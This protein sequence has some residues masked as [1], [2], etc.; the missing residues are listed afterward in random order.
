MARSSIACARCRRSKVKCVNSGV[1]SICKACEMSGRECTYP[2][3]GATITPKRSE[4][5]PGVKVEDGEN[6]RKIRKTDDFAR[7]NAPRTGEDVLDAPILSKAVYRS[8]LDIFKRHFSTEMSFLHPSFRHRLDQAANPRDPSLPPLVDPEGT[9]LLVLAML[10]LTARFHPELV[11]YHSPGQPIGASEYYATAL[12][13]SNGLS[14][15]S[16]ST[17][18]LERIQALLMLGLYEWDQSKGG[19]AWFHVGAAIRLAQMMELSYEDDMD[20]AKQTAKRAGVDNTY[21]KEVRRR[22]MWSCFVMDRMLSCGKYRDRMVNIDSLKLRLPCADSLFL[23]GKGAPV[24]FLTDPISQHD[25]GILNRYIRL[26][27][28]W[29]E[30]SIWSH[31]GGRRT[32]TYPP[33][34]EKSRFFQLRQMLLQFR[35]ELPDDLAMNQD[36]LRNHI[37]GG[38]GNAYTSLHT[39]NLISLVM[40]HREYIPHIALRCEKPDGPIDPPLF[41]KDQYKIPDGFWED[42][43][44]VLFRSARD[45]VD[46]VQSCREDDNALPESAQIVFALFTAAYTGIYAALF[47]QM[48]TVGHM[49]RSSQEIGNN[50]VGYSGLVIK[51]LKQMTPRIPMAGVYV[52]KLIFAKSSLQAHREHFLTKREM[53][54]AG[55]GLE[56][57]KSIERELKEF[58][59]LEDTNGHSSNEDSGDRSRA[60]TNETGNASM[61]GEPM[62]GI[63]GQAQQQPRSSTAWP[64]VNTLAAS[65]EA[66]DRQRSSAHGQGSG[67]YQFGF[68]RSPSNTPVNTYSHHGDSSAGH[69]SPF[70]RSDQTRSTDARPIVLAPMNQQRAMGPPGLPETESEFCQ[71][72]TTTEAN[73]TWNTGRF[74]DFAQAY[75]EQD[76]NNELVSEPPRA[77]ATA[78]AS[79]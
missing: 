22:T 67:A 16:M 78:W 43:A 35:E 73:Y 48:D 76:Y 19:R 60:S 71:W 64:A 14:G 58:G 7:R 68:Q 70:A 36:N 72:L 29:G 56:E 17:P 53:P 50:G 38:S 6:K 77:L 55:G 57:Y 42:S 33:W 44:D 20:H 3:S 12:V 59:S 32:E 46:I 15:I 45:I 66:D 4:P 23:F 30:V 69:N 8:V 40:L 39:L 24:G 47:P 49:R 13:S 28:I 21:D 25:D 65:I 74:D 1:D 51:I 11:A 37:L 75:T 54:F 79:Y 10:T 26:V 2:P 9:K 18:S 31:A 61:N 62:Q 63:E 34:D 52:K 5:T 41:P 27:N